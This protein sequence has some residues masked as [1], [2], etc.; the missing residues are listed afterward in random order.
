MIE[1]RAVQGDDFVGIVL[2]GKLGY[3]VNS[4]ISSLLDDKIGERQKVGGRAIE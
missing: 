1:R 2:A 4:T 3:T